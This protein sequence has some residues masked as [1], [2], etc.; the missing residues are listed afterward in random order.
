MLQQEARL[1]MRDGLV[2]T[3]VHVP[4]S[5]HNTLQNSQ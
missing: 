1:G 2:A 4:L 3:Y 5:M